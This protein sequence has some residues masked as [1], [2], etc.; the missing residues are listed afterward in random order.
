[1]EICEA[2]NGAL[3]EVKDVTVELGGLLKVG[4]VGSMLDHNHLA[5]RHLSLIHI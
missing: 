3:Q 1:M 2:C 5:V 4:R